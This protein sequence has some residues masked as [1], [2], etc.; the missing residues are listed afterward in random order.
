PEC[1][2]RVAPS[3]QE[4]SLVLPIWR[5]RVGVGLIL[6]LV[7]SGVAEYAA[8]EAGSFP[9]WMSFVMASGPGGARG[10]VLS[11]VL[12]G[13]RRSNDAAAILSLLINALGVCMLVWAGWRGRAMKAVSISL[14]GLAIVAI[15]FGLA[16]PG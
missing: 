6:L 4:S 8:N 13:G 9:P 5:W 7:A 16:V 3:L 12:R 10:C 2:R 14:V 1:G 11:D 15:V